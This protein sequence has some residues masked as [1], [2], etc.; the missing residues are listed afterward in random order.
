LGGISGF[1]VGWGV[2]YSGVNHNEA[3]K[4][5]VPAVTLF[6]AMLAYENKNWRVAFN[7]NNLTDESYLSTCLSRGD[8]WYGSR[9]SFVGSLSYKF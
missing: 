7:A 9:G 8:C 1:A 3:G 2:R 6:D 5:N 4:L